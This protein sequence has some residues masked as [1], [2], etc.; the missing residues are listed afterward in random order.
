MKKELAK[1][2]PLSA[3]EEGSKEWMALLEDNRK[4]IEAIIHNCF[5]SYGIYQNKGVYMYNPKALF[6][7]EVAYDLIFSSLYWMDRKFFLPSK[8]PTLQDDQFFVDVEK[9]KLY[10]AIFEEDFS[11]FVGK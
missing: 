2:V 3:F 10:L 1:L 7:S 8:S 4:V 11:D 6:V 5:L 9:A